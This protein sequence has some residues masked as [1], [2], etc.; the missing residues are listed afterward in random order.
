MWT[1]DPNGKAED[2]WLDVISNDIEDDESYHYWH[3]SVTA[4]GCIHL[5]HADNEPYSAEAGFSNKQRACEQQDSYIH[6]CDLDEYIKRLTAL[7][8]IAK[9]HFGEEWNK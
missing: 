3:A 4:N 6:I 2:H 5:H 8:D 7:R 9:K 1:K